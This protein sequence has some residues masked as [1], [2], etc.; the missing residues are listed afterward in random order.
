MAFA[1]GVSPCFSIAAS[2]VK[3]VELYRSITSEA[4]VLKLELRGRCRELNGDGT[5][6]DAEA[7]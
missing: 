4:K 6:K 1:N 5:V 3:E 2:S 7:E